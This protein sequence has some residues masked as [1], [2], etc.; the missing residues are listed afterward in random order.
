MAAKVC[1]VTLV[2]QGQMAGRI[3]KMLLNM[4]IKST[5]GYLQSAQNV[6]ERKGDTIDEEVRA[7]FPTPPDL[8]QLTPEQSKIFD[9]CRRLLTDGPMAT[10]RRR[11]SIFRSAVAPSSSEYQHLQSP[12]PFVKMS[13]KTP[14]GSLRIAIGRATASLDCSAHEAMAWWS[15]TCSR[16]RT[17]ISYEEGNPARIVA[18][19]SSAHDEI[20]ATIKNF[21]FPM[22][23]REFVGRQLAARDLNGDYV[24]AFVSTDDEI[25]YGVKLRTVRATTKWL[26]E[27]K[28]I[29]EMQCE[30]KFI[31]YFDGGGK[32]PKS[33]YNYKLPQ[34]LGAVEEMRAEFERNDEIDKLEHEEIAR[35]AR[36]VDQVYTAMEDETI[37]Q[38]VGKLGGLKEEDFEVLDSPDHHVKMGRLLA[39]N[40][41]GGTL[42]ASTV[43]DAAIEDCLATDMAFMDRAHVL[44]FTGVKREHKSINAHHMVTRVIHDFGLGFHKR[45]WVSSAIWKWVGGGRDTL[46]LVFTSVEDEDYPLDEAKVV[47]ASSEILYTYEKLPEKSG[48]PQTKLTFLFELDLGGRIPRRVYNSEGG[49]ISLL[50]F[51]SNLRVKFDKSKEIEAAVRAQ[52]VYMI[53]RHREQY[54]EQEQTLVEL[55][56]MDFNLFEEEKAKNVKMESALTTAKIAFKK[57]DKHA[58]GW[59]TTTVRASPEEVLAHCWN[60]DVRKTA[61]EHDLERSVDE[62]VSDHNILFYSAKK[63]SRSL[64]CK[65]SAPACLST[66]LCSPVIARRLA[67]SSF[68]TGST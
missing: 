68:T 16:R 18:K 34:A 39:K 19:R 35:V 54:S 49:G 4:R 45:E 60:F 50:A 67:T 44:I 48:V 29:A 64:R 36:E 26:I 17:K 7:A 66:L 12:S 27:F 33:V 62:R 30:V 53:N 20:F 38:V 11:S 56:L 51:V 41:G 9:D 46:R 14:Q 42:R 47:R 24:M 8:A 40:G 31:Q 63:V 55:A 23:H 65:T 5:L 57:G 21:P 10:P 52:N 32:V 1:E 58:W 2:I 28:S 15:A 61:R 59:A 43:I 6:F 3:P 25:G 13:C 22:A 37:E